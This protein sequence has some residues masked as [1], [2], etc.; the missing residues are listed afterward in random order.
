MIAANALVITNIATMQQTAMELMF[1][2]NDRWTPIY[3][4]VV[5]PLLL[6]STLFA[7]FLPIYPHL[8]FIMSLFSWLMLYLEALLVVPLILLGIT[9]P[10]GHPLLGQSQK[11]LMLFLALI[12]RPVLILIGFLSAVC[13][14][15]FAVFLFYKLAFPLL[16][17]MVG[18]WHLASG[19]MN[20][21]GLLYSVMVVAVVV[22]FLYFMYQLIVYSFG[23]IYQIPNRIGRWIGLQLMPSE[24][25]QVVKEITESF[26]NMVSQAGQAETKSAQEL[27]AGGKGFKPYG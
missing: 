3:F 5:I 2:I 14:S 7:F 17:D 12:T 13:T 4:G 16:N 6:I 20:D 10:Y 18:K 24:E 23:L 25:E 26:K 15:S 21:P 1:F 19:D 9:N 11:V 22:I 27:S 8:I